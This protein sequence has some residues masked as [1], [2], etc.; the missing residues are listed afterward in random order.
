MSALPINRHCGFVF[1]KGSP[2]VKK[3]VFRG[4]VFFLFKYCQQVPFHLFK[5]RVAA[6]IVHEHDYEQCDHARKVP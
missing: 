6:D 3:W 2:L 1:Q 5:G 4:N